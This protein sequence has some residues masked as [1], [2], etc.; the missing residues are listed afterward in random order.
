MVKLKCAL[1]GCGSIARE[2]LSALARLGNVDV[3][4][5]CDLSAARAE[6][7]A[8]RFGVAKWYSGLPQ[9]LDQVHP[10]LVHITTPPSSHFSIAKICLSRGLNVLCEK[11]ITVEYQEFAIL[12][13]LAIDNRCML[14][15]NQQFRFHRSIRRIQDLLSSGE[16]GVLLDLQIYVSLDSVGSGSLYADRNAPH[17]SL[18]LRGGIIGDF[19]PHIAYLAHMFTGPVIDLRTSWKKRVDHT[20]LPTDEFRAFIKGERSNAYVAFS[21]SAELNGFWISV[22][23]TRMHVEAN[24][25]EFPRLTLRRARSGEPALMSLVDGIVESGDVLK[26]T[27]ASFWRKLGGVSSYDGLPEFFAQIYHAIETKEPQP[28][29]LNEFDEVSRLVDSFT[30]PDL[31]L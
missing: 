9:M 6:V 29:P 25:F 4:A 10:D 19:L 23:G 30:R 26:G 5:V 22:S 24:L 8:E 27:I 31:E 7:T 17:F 18:A 13:Q 12:K 21:G 20:P 11:P 16:L 15:E 14:L 3:E 28:I 2:H 1:I